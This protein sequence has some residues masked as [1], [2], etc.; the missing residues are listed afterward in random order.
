MFIVKYPGY[1]SH[2]V[3]MQLNRQTGVAY[4]RHAAQTYPSA[5]YKHVMPNGIV[6]E[7]QLTI[8]HIHFFTICPYPTSLC[9]KIF[10]F[11]CNLAE[12]AK[13]PVQN[14]LNQSFSF[15]RSDR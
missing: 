11:F 13:F 5:C 10:H 2:A 8:K 1:Q 3:G 12:F 15:E 14:P 7:S 6:K 9:Q 4:L